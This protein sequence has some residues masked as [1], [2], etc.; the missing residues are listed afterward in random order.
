MP[1]DATPGLVKIFLVGS[2]T[3]LVSPYISQDYGGDNTQHLSQIILNTKNG[4][5]IYFNHP[6]GSLVHVK[7]VLKNKTILGKTTGRLAW[8]IPGLKEI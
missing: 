2:L 1:R 3:G 8:V 5:I 7:W 6:S 4:V